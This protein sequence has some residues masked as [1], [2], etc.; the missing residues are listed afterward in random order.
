MKGRC[1]MAFM[2]FS[3]NYRWHW[4]HGLLGRSIC[5]MTI[6]AWLLSSLVYGAEI[7][8]RITKADGQP[9]ANQPI[10]IKDREVGHT[11]A[12]GVY[13][14]ELSPGKHLIN[15]MGQNVEVSVFRNGNRQDIQLNR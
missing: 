13:S 14:L 6:S 4:K 12:T 11:S 10:K 15:V 9:A 5:A 3:S 2:F 8:G 1:T 7:R